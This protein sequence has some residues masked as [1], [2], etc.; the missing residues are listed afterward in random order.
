MRK[1]LFAG[2]V[3][4][5]LSLVTGCGSGKKEKSPKDAAQSSTSLGDLSSYKKIAEDT[6]QIAEKGDF[7]VAK[8]RIKDLET[9]WDNAEEKMKPLNPEKWTSV[10]KSIDRALAQ[11][12]SGQP[13]AE[14]CKS[15]LKSL[16][17]KFTVMDKK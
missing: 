15:S 11:L 13:D 4:V 16:I 12:R 9:E 1:M 14:A 3:M 6:L 2:I 8:T 10:D 5:A 17:A 7:A